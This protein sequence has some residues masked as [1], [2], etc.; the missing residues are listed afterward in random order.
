MNKNKIS[1]MNKTN[2]PYFCS[3]HQYG[4][5]YKLNSP[6]TNTKKKNHYLKLLMLIFRESYDLTRYTWNIP[7]TRN[8]EVLKSVHII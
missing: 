5:I 3:V 8:S 1:L 6:S 7:L 4:N 2:L